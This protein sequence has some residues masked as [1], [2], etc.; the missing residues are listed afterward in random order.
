M[1]KKISVFLC[2]CICVLLAVMICACSAGPKG[3]A[4]S[5][6]EDTAEQ[7]EELTAETPGDEDPA[8]TADV[9]GE[10]ADLV[11]T[12]VDTEGN[13]VTSEEIFSA[14]DVTMVNC[15]ATWCPPCVGELPELAKLNEDLKEK[16]CAIVGVLLDGYEDGA[17]ETG[18]EIMEE[19][20]VAYLNILPWDTIESEF[21]LQYIP[22]TY[23]VD[24]R[25]NIIGD[26]V[27]GAQVDMYEDQIDALLMGLPE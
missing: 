16:N 20:G 19:A 26:P 11:F 24:S 7:S 27:V 21:S 17:L 10:E 2:V 1:R 8:E 22:T 12:T 3:G 15:W 13:T 23:F 5:E 9:F 25:G 4:D 18:H 6:P 14:N